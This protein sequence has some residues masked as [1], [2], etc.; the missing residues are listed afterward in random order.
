MILQL[1]PP[2]PVSCPYG[3]GYAL[4]LIDYG[5]EHNLLFTIALN[6]TG[7][8]WSFDNTKVKLQKNISMGRLV[9]EHAVVFARED[10]KKCDASGCDN[11]VLIHKM[12]CDQCLKSMIT[13]KVNHER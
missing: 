10:V 7:E 13:N 3:D 2:I 12:Y 9:S 1:N 4:F 5:Q 6:E 8:I 11:F